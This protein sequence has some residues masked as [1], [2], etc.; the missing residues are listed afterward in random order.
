VLYVFNELWEL[1]F[2]NTLDGF[3]PSLQRRNLE[4]LAK[5][6]GFQFSDTFFPYTSGKIGPYYVFS[7]R[8]L[9]GGSQT[10][11]SSIARLIEN[12]TRE[13][14]EEYDFISGGE[15]RDFPFS[16]AVAYV[17]GKP[18]VMLF[19][20]KTIIGPSLRGGQVIHVADLNNEGSSPRDLWVPIIKKNGGNIERIVFYVDRMEE[21]VNVMKKL[22]LKSDA[23]IP[24]DRHAWGYL[25]ERGKCNEEFYKE[26]Q[27]RNEDRDAW[28]ERMLR[29]DKGFARII[30][31]LDMTPKHREMMIGV[32]KNGY[33]DLTEELTSRLK[34]RGITLE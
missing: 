3:R 10:P 16:N 7:D 28:A 4:I 8:A 22:G 15:R 26:L 9:Y 2:M 5:N 34:E 14:K 6:G 19:K 27:K 30:E 12:L 1:S 13:N 29:S 20:N 24:L 21:G 23:V 25:K 17:L 18:P 32:I 11:V 33:P 31:L